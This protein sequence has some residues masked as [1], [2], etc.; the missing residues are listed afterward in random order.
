LAEFANI[1]VSFAAI[2]VEFVGAN[3]HRFGRRH[4]NA[5][6]RK[7]ASLPQMAANASFRLIGDVNS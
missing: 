7:F 2:R 4:F 6:E 3:L 5:N 1:R